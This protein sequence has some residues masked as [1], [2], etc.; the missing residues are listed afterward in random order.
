MELGADAVGIAPAS[1]VQNGERFLSWLEKGYAGE[2]TYLFRN[3]DKRLNPAKLVPGARSIIVVGLNYFPN[4]DDFKKK[5]APHK[6]AKYAWGED[7]HYTLR[8]LLEFLRTRLKSVRG[9]LRGRIAV[10]T[11]PH[12]DKYWAQKAGLGWQGKHTILVSRR[13]GSWM[14][15]GGL[16]INIPVDRYDDEHKNR[17]GRCTACLDACP[18]SAF[19]RPYELNATRCLSYWT[20]ESKKARIPAHV[21]EDMHNWAFGCDICLGACPFNKFQR[22][23]ANPSLRRRDEIALIENGSAAGLSEEEFERLFV[24]NPIGRAGLHRIRRN[25]N[26][27]SRQGRKTER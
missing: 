1:P 25:I 20:I 17:C 3:K 24:R 19:P 13:F 9:D 6:V 14:L 16:I 4:T 11:A 12:M 15:I 10:D 27:T 23:A 2:I 8:H 7:Y 18:T 21:K 26:A 5:A 22:P